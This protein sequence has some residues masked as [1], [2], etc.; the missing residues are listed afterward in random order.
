MPLIIPSNS[1]SDGGYVVDNSCRFNDDSSDTLSRT[2]GTPT[3]A[4]KGTISLWVKRGNLTDGR[5]VNSWGGSSVQFF[6]LLGS[7]DILFVG[8]FD[9]SYNLELKTNRVFRDTSAWYHF[10][11]AF[12]TTQSTASN[13]AKIYVNGIQETSFSQEDYPS[14]NL[15]LN[16]GNSGDAFRIGVRDTAELFDGY[17]S[18]VVFIDGQQLDPTSFGEFDEDSGV[19]KPID[20]SGLT[21]GTNGFYLDF[22]DSAA[23]GADVSGNTNNFTVN[24]L[25]AIDQSTDTCT[26]NGATWN[27]LVHYSTSATF[28]QGNLRITPTEDTS[29]VYTVSTLAMPTVSGSKWYAEFQPFVNN[30]VG[31]IGILDAKQISYVFHNNSDLD[32][33]N[34]DTSVGRVTYRIGNGIIKYP[35]GQSVSTGVTAGNNDVIMIALDSGSG[36]I[37]FGKNGTWFNSGNPATG[38]NGVDFTGQS[39]WTSGVDEFVFFAGDG[40]TGGYDGWGANFSGGTF[41]TVSSG[42]SDG[43]GYGNFEYAP[44]SGY[45]SLCTAN[46][47]EVLG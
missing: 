4:K 1:I 26:N 15:D 23:L 17:M 37:W 6:T 16:F 34:A 18:E 44:P 10:V 42:N 31:I 21:F 36:K 35:S 25:T 40:N 29:R 47:S 28:S 3:N 38:S 41:Y 45:L 8:D 12:D 30:T 39:W 43:N 46:L 19:W 2:I 33:Q 7:D 14:Q 32:N 27:S 20:V 5:L 11:F 9:G 13:R 24:N 22:E